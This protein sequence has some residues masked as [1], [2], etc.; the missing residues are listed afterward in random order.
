VITL[1]DLYII[2]RHVGRQQG[3]NLTGWTL[4]HVLEFPPD[5]P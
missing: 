3:D 5:G 2:L 1:A 4:L